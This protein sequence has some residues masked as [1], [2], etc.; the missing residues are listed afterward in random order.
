M[1]KY[2]YFNKYHTERT[3]KL[4]FYLKSLLYLAENILVSGGEEDQQEVLFECGEGDS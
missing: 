4:L 2:A 1:I 3:L